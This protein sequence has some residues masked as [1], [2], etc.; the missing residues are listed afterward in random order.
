M[1][2]KLLKHI[3][4]PVGNFPEQSIADLP[5]QIALALVA[6]GYAVSLAPTAPSQ[7]PVS[8]S[9]SALVAQDAPGSIPAPLPGKRPKRAKKG[10]V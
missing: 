6:N 5:E 4:C 1:L 9:G 7:E 8:L 2:I 3:A 10:A